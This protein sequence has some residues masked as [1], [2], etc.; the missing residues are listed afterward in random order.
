MIAAPSSRGAKKYRLRGMESLEFYENMLWTSQIIN[1]IFISTNAIGRRSTIMWMNTS[2]ISSYLFNYLNLSTSYYSFILFISKIVSNYCYTYYFI[3]FSIIQSFL[4]FIIPNKNVNTKYHKFPNS[5]S[6][7][8]C[9]LILCFS[10]DIFLLS[11]ISGLLVSSSS[12]ATN[13]II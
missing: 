8:I 2:K 11:M 12:K 3:K 7:F 1:V 6:Y 4:S 5:I 13:L 10:M 9:L